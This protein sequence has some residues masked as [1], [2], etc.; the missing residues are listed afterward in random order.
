MSELARVAMRNRLLQA[1]EPVAR[2][3]AAAQKS[4]VLDIW[5]G[6]ALPADDDDKSAV[7]AAASAEEELEQ[8]DDDEGEDGGAGEGAK[9]TDD[10]SAASSLSRSSAGSRFRYMEAFVA[11]VDHLVDQIDSR[12][13]DAKEQA[14]TAQKNQRRAATANE[15]A[16]RKALL[17]RPGPFGEPP[18][19]AAAAVA[20]DDSAPVWHAGDTAGRP[21]RQSFLSQASTVE[22]LECPHHGLSLW[23]TNAKLLSLSAGTAAIRRAGGSTASRGFLPLGAAP[24]LGNTGCE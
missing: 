20:A 14:K 24:V 1:R 11:M 13:L 2:V 15:I 8:E 7:A 3:V 23:R 22:D 21:R 10:K 18:A 4:A 12:L 19:A 5:M 9:P 6:A 16:R 17:G